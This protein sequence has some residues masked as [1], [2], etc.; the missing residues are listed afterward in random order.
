MDSAEETIEKRMRALELECSGPKIDFTACGL[1]DLDAL[2][3]AL[4]L[5]QST[6]PLLD[7]Y[8]GSNSIGDEG[9]EA[10]AN[11]LGAHTELKQL[12]LGANAFKEVGTEAICNVLPELV[13]LVTLSLGSACFGNDQATSLAASLISMASSSLQGLYL[14]STS[15]TDEGILTLS[16]A[17]TSGKFHLKTLHLGENLFGADGVKALAEYL[18]NDD[19]LQ[20]LF[21]SDNPMELESM[22]AIGEA[23]CVNKTLCLLSLGNCMITDEGVKPLIAALSV[24]EHLQSLHLWKNKLTETSA[25]LLMEILK[26]HNNSLTDVQLFGNEI[27]DFDAIQEAIREMLAQN[28]GLTEAE[29]VIDSDAAA[30]APS[31]SS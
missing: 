6:T 17:L 27:E 5:Y 23:L 1:D 25:E 13:N 26:R 22:E 24:N 2:T 18:E 31:S 9:M 11:S 7:L 10:I 20:Q 4:K 14:N 16:V 12:Y 29:A 30:L 8:L 15:L 3:I 28:K 21:L 19:S